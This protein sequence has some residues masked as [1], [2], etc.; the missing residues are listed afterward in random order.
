MTAVV[1]PKIGK[2]QFQWNAGGWLGAAVGGTAWMVVTAGFLVSNQEVVV[3]AVPFSCFLITSLFAYGL[4]M[5]RERLD[6]FLSLMALLGVLSITT[7]VA[8]LTT[9]KWASPETLAQMSWPS[10]YGWNVVVL[11][12]APGIML[13]FYVAECRANARQG[14]SKSC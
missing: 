13:W 4:W 11:L 7:P 14:G 10:W 12:L 3:A 6:P 2:G 1:R 9:C 8:W 5:R